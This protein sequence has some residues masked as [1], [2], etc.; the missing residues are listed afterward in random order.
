MPKIPEYQQRQLESSMVGIPSL[1]TSGKRIA[2]G[3]AQLGE[4]GKNVFGQQMIER[5]QAIDT[6]E[7]NKQATE[8]EVELEKTFQ[9]HQKTHAEDPK[10]KTDLFKSQA[11][12]ML[13]ERVKSTKSTA[14]QQSVAVIGQRILGNKLAQE[15]KWALDQESNNALINVTSTVQT[16][17][18]QAFEAGRAGDFQLATDTFKRHESVLV[19]SKMALNPDSYAKLQKSVP[20]ILAKG[21]ID[22]MLTSHPDKVSEYIKSLPPDTLAPEEIKKYKKEAQDAILNISDTRQFEYLTDVVATKHPE[23][24]GRYMAGDPTLISDLETHPDKK[25]AGLLRDIILKQNPVSAETKA[26]SALDM[27]MSF[28]NLGVS[29]RDGKYSAKANLDE[30]LRFQHDVMKMVKEQVIAPKTGQALIEK[31]SGPLAKKIS[32]NAKPSMGERLGFGEPDAMQAGL[33]AVNQWVDRQKSALAP[34]NL[35]VDM[36]SEFVERM[37]REK[38]KDRKEAAALIQD[39]IASSFQK[40]YPGVSAMVDVPGAYFGKDGVLAPGVSNSKAPTQQ[41]VTKPY[42]RMFSPSTGKYWRVY[43]NGKRELDSDQNA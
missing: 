25:A 38:P 17:A 6:I 14:A 34:D 23:L 27:Y 13:Q 40:V 11:E 12:Q 35:K 1:D 2:E 20:A 18:N 21:A 3:V 16:L 42:T 22:G 32:E 24:F 7:A 39:V 10:D 9:T 4:T 19:S 30:V 41:K 15:G 28:A 26:S 29:K 5:Q 37:D 33:R 43:P 36:M 31:L 8:Y